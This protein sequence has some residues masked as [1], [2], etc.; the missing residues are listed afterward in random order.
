MY[1]YF[2][3]CLIINNIQTKYRNHDENQ[4]LM[5]LMRIYI[6]IAMSLYILIVHVILIPIA[7]RRERTV[8]LHLRQQKKITRSEFVTSMKNRPALYAFAKRFSVGA[9]RAICHY[10]CHPAGGTGRQKARS[11][12]WRSLVLSSARDE[13]GFIIHRFGRPCEL[14]AMCT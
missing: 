5:H 9:S 3:A 7:I 8:L 2:V 12:G 1:K 6:S 14:W 13:R 4:S 11:S 10:T